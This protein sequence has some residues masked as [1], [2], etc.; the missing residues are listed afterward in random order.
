MFRYVVTERWGTL[1]IKLVNRGAFTIVTECE[2]DISSRLK[3]L[4]FVNKA[5]HGCLG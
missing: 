2:R 1:F 3:R 5:T 4:S